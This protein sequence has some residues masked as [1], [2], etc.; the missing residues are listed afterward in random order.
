[1]FSWQEL[2]EQGKALGGALLVHALMAAL[3]MLGTLNWKPFRESEPV[4]L[5][6]EAV[7][8]DTAEIKKQRDE[9]RRAQE[10][11]ERRQRR[12]EEL[13]RQRE[14]EAAE[15]EAERQRQQRL[16]EQRK[17]EAADRLQAL[18]LER[19]RKLEE[20]RLKSQREL[21]EIRRQREAAER[22]RKIEEERLKQI[23][24]VRQRERQQEEQRLA[25]EAEAQRKAAEEAAAFKAGRMAQLSDQYKAAIQNFVTANWRRPMSTQPG[26]EC[27]L[28][29][30]QIPGGEVISASIVRPC[31][32][33][34]ATR[35]S[36]LDAVERGGS[37]PYRGFEDAFSREIEFT[38][39]YNGD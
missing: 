17:Q 32:G 12:D 39:I 22:E 11:E 35:R 38:F 25:A 30:I 37:L 20:E 16:E 13:R 9:A 21:E 1:M 29:I 2:L 24:A 8:V 7:I 33:D 28:K 36:I 18:R 3:V 10:M 5:T 15:A 14:R 26:L 23:E 19:E 34:D 27:R 31:N 4:G 6:I